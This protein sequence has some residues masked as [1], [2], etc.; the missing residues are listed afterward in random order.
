MF[1]SAETLGTGGAS[2]T[3]S[4]TSSS[5][6]TGGGG[7]GGSGAGGSGGA[8]VICSSLDLTGPPA[9]TS[10]MFT[11]E[12]TT[13]PRLALATAEGDLAMMV[14]AREPAD[15]LFE[16]IR[17]VHMAFEPWGAWPPSFEKEYGLCFFCG[18]SFALAP[19]MPS[20]QPAIASFAGPSKGAEFPTMFFFRQ[21]EPF[22][23][24]DYYPTADLTEGF[25]DSEVRGLARGPWAHLAAWENEAGPY[26]FLNLSLIDSASPVQDVF[27]GVACGNMPFPADVAT[28]DEGFLIATASGRPFSTCNEDDGTPGPPDALQVIR[29]DTNT[30]KTS[31][32]FEIQEPDPLAHISLAAA[33]KGAWLVYQNNGQSAFQPPPVQAVRLDETGAMAGP[34]FQ[35]TADGETQGPIAATSMGSGLAV[36]WPVGSPDS[37]ALAV[38]LFSASGEKVA[39]ALI[40]VGPYALHGGVLSLLA[41]PDGKHVLLA[42]ADGVPGELAV[43]HV[44]RFSCGGE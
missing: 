8:P 41:S 37:P 13:R 17:N 3:G 14:V 39:S 27:T 34:V 43:T 23:G 15:P 18:R 11:D 9:S 42:W 22:V 7:D 19:A 30:L 36:A 38:G 31:L 4:V 5:T 6:S 25:G 40:E 12:H 10:L 26:R 24:Y 32:T 2:A 29:F 33:S 1:G 21:I 16:H 44:A 35:I 28:T 20:L